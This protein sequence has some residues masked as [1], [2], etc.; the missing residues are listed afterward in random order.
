MFELC[1]E[2]DCSICIS[3]GCINKEASSS[4]AQLEAFILFSEMQF[5]VV[6]SDV[7]DCFGIVLTLH[8]V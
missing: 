3:V 7:V 2:V 6:K 1:T 8:G 4:G 5:A